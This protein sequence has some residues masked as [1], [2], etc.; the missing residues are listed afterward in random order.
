M[1]PRTIIA[2]VLMIFVAGSVVYLVARELNDSSEAPQSEEPGKQA[3]NR[4]SPTSLPATAPGTSAV[5]TAERPVSSDRKIIVYYFHGYARCVNCLRF[6]A[7][8]RSIIKT[9]FAEAVSHGRLEWRVVNVEAPGNR[10]FIKDYELY[11]KSVVL[12]ETHDGKRI[13]WKNLDRIWELVYSEDAYSAYVRR[14]LAAYL[15]RN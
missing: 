11:T 9:S 12:V 10:H 1:K 5:A 4:P 13:R 2:A 7:W 8:T 6:E 14:E 15:K 3:E